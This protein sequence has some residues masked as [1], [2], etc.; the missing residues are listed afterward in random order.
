MPTVSR[1]EAE[2][3]FVLSLDIGSSSIRV[4]VFD[5]QALDIEGLAAKGAYPVHYTD[6]GGV[7]ANADEV[8]AALGQAIDD[9][10]RAAG[11][12]AAQIGAVASCSLVSNVLGVAHGRP[13]TPGLLLLGHP[14]RPG[15]RD[16]ARPGRPRRL[17]SARR[18]GHPHAAT[19]R[20]ASCG[21]SAPRRI[22]WRAPN[23]GCRWASTSTCAS[24]AA[25]PARSPSPRGPA[26][27][28]APR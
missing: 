21:C 1:A 4:M 18:H 10:L 14:Q 11:P 20:R 8:L 15:Y 3:P 6:D 27:S 12:L 23:T 9:T 13:S 5:R 24:S 7:E 25:A 16:P 28:I 17:A 22:C 2:A 26:C 19:C